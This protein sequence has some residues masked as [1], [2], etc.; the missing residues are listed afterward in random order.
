MT[1]YTDL[2]NAHK[3]KIGKLH[4]RGEP[5]NKGEYRYIVTVIL[6]NEKNEMLIQKRAADKAEWPNYW[7]YS[8]SGSVF[9]GEELYKAAE[10]E[11]Y[12]E[13]GILIDLKNIASQLTM[14]FEEGWNEIFILQ[15]KVSEEE[16]KMQKEEVQEL[17]WV[18]EKTYLELLSS[19]KFMPYLFGEIAFD[20]LRSQNKQMLL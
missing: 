18:E 8:A 11:L 13:T 19:G 12:E 17:L 7:S 10:R 16:I 20:L 5:V 1:E 6:F 15:Q 3:K 9:P 4:L 14:S 2:Y